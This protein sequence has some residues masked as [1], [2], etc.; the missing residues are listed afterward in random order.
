MV[1]SEVGYATQVLQA[2]GRKRGG[3]ATTHQ[4]PLKALAQQ[5]RVPGA[6]GLFGATIGTGR[7]TGCFFLNA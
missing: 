4:A 6:L 7:T 5:A 1:T 2:E 3:D